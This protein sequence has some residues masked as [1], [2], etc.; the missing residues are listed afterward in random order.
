VSDLQPDLEEVLQTEEHGGNEE[1]PVTVVVSGVVRS[2]ALPEKSGATK[3][4]ANVTTIPQKVLQADH[5]RARTTLLATGG[6]MRFAF[7]AASAQ[8][9]SR[10]ALWPAGLPMIHLGDDEVWVAADAGTVSVTV[11]S[12]RWAVGE[13][14]G[15]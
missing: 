15:K 12:G 7:N 6:S 2:Q 11:I 3:T 10:M 9:P 5:R 13:D 1:I 14:G 8:D 4:I